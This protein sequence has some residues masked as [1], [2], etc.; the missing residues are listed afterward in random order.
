[1]RPLLP[2]LL[3]AAC[4][5]SSDD[6]LPATARVSDPAQ[7]LPTATTPGLT[8][9][10]GPNT[11]QPQ[12]D[13]DVPD[14]DDFDGDG[15]TREMGDCNDRDRTVNP[16]A[17]EV[18]DDVDNDCNGAVDEDLP[19]E[20]WYETDSGADGSI[21]RVT[22]Y[23][24]DSWGRLTGYET[25][26]DG[27]GVWD[28]TTTYHYDGGGRVQSIDTD[29]DGDGL[30]DSIRIYTYEGDKLVRVDTD[31]G[32]D[33]VIDRIDSYV[34]LGDVY[35]QLRYDTDADGQ[36][37]MVYHYDWTDFGRV[38]QLRLSYLDDEG[39]E[40]LANQYKYLYDERD[41]LHQ[42]HIDLAADLVV[43]S[44]SEYHYSDAGRLYRYES[45]TNADLVF[46]NRTSYKFDALGRTEMIE[47]DTG[48]DGVDTRTH[49]TW[50]CAS[51]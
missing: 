10:E 44:I 26:S 27:D 29:A 23:H 45:D 48:I 51:K 17:R 24:Y 35:I 49:I 40:Y 50:A 41:W 13:T 25:D 30:V 8:D 43:D 12:A 18:C 16:A 6:A 11:W 42:V 34:W 21:D 19:V 9:D 36:P 37:E 14:S 15:W 22:L 4:A 5:P 39:I 2:L 33:G 7:T 38:D 47:S 46:D 28:Q 32:P 1:M 20:R 31:A 3:L